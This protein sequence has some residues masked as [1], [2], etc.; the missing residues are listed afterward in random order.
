MSRRTVLKK[1]N[2][3]KKRSY[4]EKNGH[5]KDDCWKKRDDKKHAENKK[6]KSSNHKPSSQKTTYKVA[7]ANLAECSDNYSFESATEDNFF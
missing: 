5:S 7:Q 2:A 4:C 6:P 3:S 1:P